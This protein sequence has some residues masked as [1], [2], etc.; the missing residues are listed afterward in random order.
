MILAR[1]QSRQCLLFFQSQYFL[2]QIQLIPQGLNLPLLQ[3]ARRIRAFDH[4]LRRASAYWFQA[5]ALAKI[6]ALS[7]FT[8]RS[9]KPLV[10]C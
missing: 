3:R 9:M 1:R 10:P 8:C 2:Q 6:V 5:V 4:L 7:S